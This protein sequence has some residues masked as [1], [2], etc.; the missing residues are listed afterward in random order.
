MAAALVDTNLL[1]YAY[2]AD[3]KDARCRK[4]KEVLA[5]LILGGEGFVSVQG[6]AELSSVFLTKQ[7]PPLAPAAIQA[8]LRD[9]ETA[10][11][12]LSPTADTVRDALGAVAAHRLSFWDAMVWSVARENGLGEV[13]SEDFQ[14]GRSLQGVRFRNPLR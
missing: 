11:T 10:L 3:A 2:Q 1:V 6:L 5:A 4:A 7:K 13:L 14:D 9:L 8:I 12:V